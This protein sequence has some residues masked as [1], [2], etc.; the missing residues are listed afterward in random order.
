M[1]SDAER[2]RAQLQA[3][4]ARRLAARQADREELAAIAQLIPDAVE[5][6]VTKREIARF[7]GMSRV[8]INELLRRHDQSESD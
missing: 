8:W 6:G 7:T 3:H 5:A 1:E 4:G 2:L